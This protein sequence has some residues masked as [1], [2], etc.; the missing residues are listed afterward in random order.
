MMILLMVS[1]GWWSRPVPR[2]LFRVLLVVV[3]T[4]L[5]HSGF[6]LFLL[7]CWSIDR[8]ND[9]AGV[10]EL[11]SNGFV[12]VKYPMPAPLGVKRVGKGRRSRICFVLR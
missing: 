10:V 2:H 5:L 7:L 8:H 4:A 12:I 1:L 3:V 6:L 11:G 9:M